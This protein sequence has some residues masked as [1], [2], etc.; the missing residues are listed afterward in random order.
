[1]IKELGELRIVSIREVWP[2][3]PQHFSTWL[4]ENIN[5]LG[6]AIGIALELRR[7]EVGVGAFSLDILAHDIVRDRIVIIENQ[8]SRTDHDHLGKLI[9]YAAGLKAFVVIW[10]SPEFRDEHRAALDWL[11]ESTDETK[12]FFG[13]QIEA[14]RI[15]DSRPAPNF[16]LL[17]FPNGWQKS[18]SASA[19]QSIDDSVRRALFLQ[20]F[21]ELSS[22]AR[23]SG[24]PKAQAATGQPDL[25]LD[26]LSA[27][28]YIAVAFSRDLFTAGV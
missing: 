27:G 7:R 22:V 14:L 6:D 18:T 10:I 4:A 8:L 24:F 16:K 19:Q 12:E 20:Y 9:T 3:E 26:R 23:Q 15:D 17:A 1:M 2:L 13:I 11:N 25:V 5:K 28:A 21:S